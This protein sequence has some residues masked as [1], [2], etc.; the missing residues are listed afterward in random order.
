MDQH[1]PYVVAGYVLTAGVL[2]S[3]TIWLLR[4]L[5]RAERLQPADAQE[6]P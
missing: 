3:Y 5:T 6:R 4:K 2:G 1:W